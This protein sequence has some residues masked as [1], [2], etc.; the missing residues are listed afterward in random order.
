MEKAERNHVL[1]IDDRTVERVNAAIAGHPDLMA[2]RSSLTL[3]EGMT[4]ITKNVFLNIKNESKTITL[5][6][7]AKAAS[8][9]FM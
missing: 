5:E 9:P 4:G 3:S 8:Q 1:P 7:S 2:G 6:V